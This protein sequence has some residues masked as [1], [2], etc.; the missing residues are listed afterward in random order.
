[1]L[2]MQNPAFSEHP[3]IEDFFLDPVEMLPL[4][5]AVKLDCCDHIFNESIIQ[6][7][8]QRSNIPLCPLCRREFKQYFLDIEMR[9][10]VSDIQNAKSENTVDTENLPAPECLLLPDEIWTKILSFVGPKQSI[11]N[12][13]LGV[14][15][16]FNRV[17][18]NIL[19]YPKKFATIQEPSEPGE[20]EGRI[21]VTHVTLQKNG[22]IA[23]DL[24]MKNW[25]L[26]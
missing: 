9:A 11:V 5:K 24:I 6:G 21:I 13:M 26:C 10:L 2:S 16:I 18:V 22:N 14:C 20:P 3:L 1:M 8:Q 17:M 19:F 25:R 4:N 12:Q 15:Q 23:M 7:L